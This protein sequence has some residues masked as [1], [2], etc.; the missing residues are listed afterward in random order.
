[1]GNKQTTCL[2]EAV[3]IVLLKEPPGMFYNFWADFY[4]I[5]NILKHFVNMNVK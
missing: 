3:S 4:F 1:V 2:T 5:L